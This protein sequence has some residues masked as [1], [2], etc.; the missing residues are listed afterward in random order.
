M[1]KDSKPENQG[2]QLV[3][4]DE[5]QTNKQQMVPYEG[6]E[7]TQQLALYNEEEQP[8]RPDPDGLTSSDHLMIMSS[9]TKMDQ[10]SIGTNDKDED[11]Q[12]LMFE[13]GRLYIDDLEQH[14]SRRTRID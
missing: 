6:G 7:Q 8:K 2:L 3:V 13:E 4:F 14:S 9:D 1:S 12:V 11:D 5:G 10:V